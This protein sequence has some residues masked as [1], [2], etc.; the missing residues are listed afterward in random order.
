MVSAKFVLSLFKKH[1]FITSLLSNTCKAVLAD[2]ITQ[3]V[4]ENRKE[5]DKRRTLMFGTFGLVYLGGWQ[6]LLFCKLFSNV[7]N[8][9]QIYN[10]SRVNQ[11][12]MLTFLDMGIHTPFLYFPA[13]YTIKCIAEKKCIVDVKEMYQKNIYQDLFSIWKLWIPAQIYN[14]NYVPLYL[15]MPFITSVSFIWTII[16]SLTHGRNTNNQTQTSI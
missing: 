16:L 13:F 12:C 6:H 9:M 14:F 7:S 4:L 2:V 10:I 3:K 5:L 1:S 11:S 8:I 15:R